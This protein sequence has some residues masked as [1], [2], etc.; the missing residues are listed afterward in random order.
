MTRTEMMESISKL[1][2]DIFDD[3]SILISEQSSAKDIDDWDSLNN[4]KIVIAVEKKF[5]IRFKAAEI[6]TWNN[7][8]EMCDSI[9]VLLQGK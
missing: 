2:R 3:E 7:V 6:R 4:I 8:G 5:K 1:I 9:D